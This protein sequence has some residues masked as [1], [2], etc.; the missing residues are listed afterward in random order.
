MAPRNT[1]AK[2]SDGS[3]E[4]FSGEPGGDITDPEFTPAWLKAQQEAPSVPVNYYAEYQAA[5]FAPGDT[6]AELVD[7]V[8]GADDEAAGGDPA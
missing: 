3:A 4:A 8:H 6:P 7:T 5:N 1:K 2:E